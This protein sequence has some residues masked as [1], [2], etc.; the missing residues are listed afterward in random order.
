MPAR[1]LA[2][3]IPTDGEP[4]RLG[5]RSETFQDQTNNTTAS[6]PN[7]TKPVPDLAIG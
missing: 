1:Q 3:K 4:I 7:K 2:L 6:N 5:R